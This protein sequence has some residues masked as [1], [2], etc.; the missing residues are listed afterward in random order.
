METTKAVGGGSAFKQQLWFVIVFCS[1]FFCAFLF[2]YPV[3][4]REEADELAESPNSSV[5]CSRVRAG[6]RPSMFLL[7]V[8]EVG[9]LS[10][11]MS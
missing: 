2:V 5:L 6:N 8:E 10:E 11:Q 7:A 9:E 4:L 3:C 1:V